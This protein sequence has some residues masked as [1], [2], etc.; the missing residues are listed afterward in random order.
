[1]GETKSR[2]FVGAAHAPGNGYIYHSGPQ[3]LSSL[4]WYAK[5][6][7]C[8]SVVEVAQRHLFIKC[9]FVRAKFELPVVLPYL[10]PAAAG[11]LLQEFNIHCLFQTGLTFFLLSHI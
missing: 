8:H 1:M 10:F 6:V 5:E 9:V 11:A 4:Q 7:T 3:L 2:Q